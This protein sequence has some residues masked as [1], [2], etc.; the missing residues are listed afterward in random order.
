MKQKIIFFD[1]D[2]TLYG[3]EHKTITKEVEDAIHKTQQLGHLCFV[4]TGRPYGYIA[5]NVKQIGFDGYILANGANIKYQDSD[6]STKILDYDLL[7]ELVENLKKENI[8]YVLQTT[9]YCYMSK[10]HKCLSDFYG[11]CNIDFKNFCYEYNEDEILK[12]VVKMEAWV[13]N[14]KEYQY[15]QSCLDGFNYELH[16]DNHSMEI[17][18]KTVSK[19]TGIHEIIKELNL[20]IDDSYCFGDGPNDV[21]MFEA[22][23]HPIAMGNAIDIIKEKAEEV[24]LDVNEN[25]VAHKLVDLFGL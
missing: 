10:N 2:G 20:S 12:R 24:C 9:T 23:A 5:D 21:E 8:E 7:K 15:V 17:Y 16:P 18:A 19:A 13:K 4:A 11:H 25:G 14:E 22:V 6:F 3:G 1:I